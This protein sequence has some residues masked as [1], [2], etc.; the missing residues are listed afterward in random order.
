MVTREEDVKKSGASALSISLTNDSRWADNPETLGVF[1][2]FLTSIRSTVYEK[3]CRQDLEH[4]VMWAM[5]SF[6]EGLGI[7]TTQIDKI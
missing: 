7:L 2:F 6:T 3:Q 5:V 1:F 4:A